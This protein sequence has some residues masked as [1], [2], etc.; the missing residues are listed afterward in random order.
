MWTAPKALAA[1]IGAFFGSRA[2]DRDLDDELEAHLAMLADDNER[3][4]MT[5]S[6]ARRSARLRLGNVD[7]LKERHRDVRGLPAI[8]TLIQDL[9]YALRTMRRDAAFAAF[10]ITIVGLGV[11]A[12]VTIFSVV[13]AILLRP[14]PFQDPSR[15]VWIA[16]TGEDGLSGQTVPVNHFVDLRSRSKSLSDVAAYFAHYG[17]GDSKLTG[18]GEPLRLTGIAVSQNFFGV[19]GVAPQLGR[20]FAGDECKGHWG[21]P[22]VVVLSDRLWTTHFAADPTIV[23]RRLILNDAPVTVV[24]VMPPSFDFAAVFAPGSRVDVYLPLPL[25]DE[26]DHY[27][28]TVSMVGR[29]KAGVTVPQAQAEVKV[30]GPQIRRRDPDRFFALELT[31]LDD[32]VT[33]RLRPALLVLVSAVG[34]VMLIVC[35]NLSNLLMAR[36]ATRQREMAIRAALGAGRRRLIRQMLTESLVLSGCGAA[37]GLV[38]AVA[39]TR[40][41]AQLDAVSLPLLGSVRIDVGALVVAVLMAMLTG[42]VFGLVPALR[43]PVVAVQGSLKDGGRVSSPGRRDAWIRGVLVVSEIAFA[44]VLLVGAGLLMRSFLRVLDVNLGFRPERTAVL[45]IDPSARYS[46]RAERNAYY[47]E[48]LRRVKAIPGV[49]EAG[50]TDVLP[51]GRNRSWSAGAKERE[52]SRE[53]LP[54]DAFVRVVSDGYLKAMGIPL[55]AGRDFTHHDTASSKRVI[56]INET[57]AR[58]LWPGQDPIGHTVK[59]VDPEREVIGVVGDVR[60]L[61]LEKGSGGEMYLPI[62]QT[63]DYSSVDLVVRTALPPAAL[64]SEIR[65]ALKPLEP[66][67]PTNEFRTLQQIVDKAVSPRRLVVT[68]LVGFAG[69]ALVLAS[70]GIYALIS[71][72][73]NQRTQEL[74]IRTAL[75]ASAGALQASVMIETMRLAGLGLLAGLAAS[76]ALARTLDGLLFGVEANDPFTFVGMTIVLATVAAAAGYLPARRASR[77]DPLVALRGD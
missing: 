54:P 8:E 13:D 22:Q 3:A 24:G 63:D 53:H 55:R 46:T 62:R 39:G 38:V 33:G 45:R 31:S 43:V 15:L 72:S 50:L 37:L 77:I 58:A 56:L 26:L 11:G 5:P 48:A 1:R 74:G 14:L 12:S 29:L 68:L 34:M 25:T 76:W 20:V 28:N 47:D 65:V 73:V 49:E 4:G 60:H 2:I 23:G 17:V 42:L 57:L 7:A 41:L 9:R 40:A 59:Y 10:A 32:H 70:L 64:A 66:N 61:A 30:L 21:A 19:L 69:F 51:L 71:Y 75:G 27:G 36:T 44:C 52:Y 67:L 6:E 18:D 16:N 35:A